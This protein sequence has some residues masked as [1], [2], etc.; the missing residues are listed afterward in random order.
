MGFFAVFGR[1]NFV[2]TD[3]SMIAV[4]AHFIVAVDRTAAI[5]HGGGR[6]FHPRRW[7]IESLSAGGRYEDF[8][9]IPD[10]LAIGMRLEIARPPSGGFFFQ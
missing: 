3:P 7:H 9:V 5:A 6:V 4:D 10:M 8:A 2:V 1:R